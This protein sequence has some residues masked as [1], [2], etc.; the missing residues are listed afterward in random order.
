MAVNIQDIM[1]HLAGNKGQDQELFLSEHPA[2]L[3]EEVRSRLSTYFLS[4]FGHVYEQYRFSMYAEGNIIAQ[5]AKGLFSNSDALPESSRRIATHLYH[6]ATHP[7]IK[8]GELY[9]TLI[10]GYVFE[11][12]EVRALGIFKTELKNGYFEVKRT[13]SEVQMDY[14]EGID[15]N[16][17]DKGCLIL[18]H[19]DS[20]DPIVLIIDQQS[21]GDEAVY[22]RDHFLGLEQRQ[23][24]FSLTQNVLLSTKEFL[25]DF[26]VEDSEVS[27]TEQIDLMNRSVQYFRSNEV[28]DKTDFERKVLE[29]PEV[30]KS[31]RRFQQEH[32]DRTLALD[33]DGF[34]I[35]MPAV[36][37]QARVFKSVLKLDRN[38]HVYIHGN[39][40]LISRGIDPDGRTYYK[41]YFENES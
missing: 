6:C 39:R 33:E 12:V 26:L 24:N 34:G 19:P 23:T 5:E 27:K 29:S 7:R 16:K 3:S 11:G 31:F 38:F 10:D 36:K 4:R 25:S 21:R 40:D 9:V 18:E 20:N 30:I 8:P 1:I 14:R 28:F 35:S 13:R 41:I 2:Q 15:I 22:W 32:P 37:Q 17:F